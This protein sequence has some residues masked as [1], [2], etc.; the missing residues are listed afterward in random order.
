M[1]KKSKNIITTIIILSIFIAALYFVFV[2]TPLLNS[3]T[4]NNC[5]VSLSGNQ[6]NSFRCDSGNCLVKGSATC[7]Q[8]TGALQSVKFRTNG[9]WIAWDIDGDGQ[10][11]CYV[12]SSAGIC[13]VLGNGNNYHEVNNIV[14][15]DNMPSYGG[16]R[17]HGDMSN[18]I[19]KT[20]ETN[21]NYCVKSGYRFIT[22]SGCDIT[23]TSKLEYTNK[24]E[25]ILSGSTS[26]AYSCSKTVN[27]NG[28]LQDTA[29]YE[30]S[31]AGIYSTKEYTLS[32]GQTFTF[33]GNIN[34]KVIDNTLACSSNTCTNDGSGFYECKNING[35]MIKSATSTPCQIGETCTAGSCSTPFTITSKFLDSVDR[36]KY[37]YNTGENIILSYQINS[38]KVSN[39]NIDFILRNNVQQPL[40]TITKTVSFP[41]S[42]KIDFGQVSAIG[43]YDIIAKI[44]YNNKETSS[45][46]YSFR[47][48]NGVYI[49]IRAFSG[50]AETAALYTNEDSIIEIRVFTDA[51]ASTPYTTNTNVTATIEGQ[52]V[53]IPVRTTYSDGVY[54]YKLHVTTPGTLRVAAKATA[55]NYESSTF[56]EEFVV[57]PATVGVTF[58]NMDTLTPQGGL[59][60]GTY[61]ILF[62]TKT[63][64][65]VLLSTNNKI[66][67]LKSG[68]QLIDIPASSIS[69]SNGEYSIAYNFPN[70]IGTYYFNVLS[71]AQGYSQGSKQS[72]AIS[73]DTTSEN[74]ESQCVVDSDCTYPKVCN[75]G[76]CNNNT[77]YWIYIFGI[78][79][80]VI[81][82]IIIVVLVV[83]L[84]KR[85]QSQVS[86]SF[87]IQ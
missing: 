3:F 42:D 21:S 79:G 86:N 15:P 82:I 74:G 51:S 26:A 75:A 66:Q 25:E 54:R 8:Q 56:T 48:S 76:V 65:G 77:N 27:I 22:G 83:K 24:N 32:A 55:Y 43:D 36:Q 17:F 20:T 70:V 47:V 81:A 33:E 41:Y 73:I 34:Y 18:L 39:A 40:K 10:L 11:E 16:L 84:S 87:I 46:P 71:D 64:Q 80:A 12:H 78:S 29:T 49:V 7:S 59:K 14:L 72:G 31:T 2:K 19:V 28:V 5:Y 6:T 13:T 30:G 44:K 68:G 45:G 9:D 1:N 67:L 57:S 38:N 4:D 85:S 60:P 23:Q 62:N 69:G 35:C 61:N 53:T 37:G 50:T 52:T 63:P 58:I